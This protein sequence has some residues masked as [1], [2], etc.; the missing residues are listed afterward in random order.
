MTCC[1]SDQQQRGRIEAA[2]RHRV[3]ISDFPAFSGI[4]AGAPVPEMVAY[5]ATQEDIRQ[6]RLGY[7]IAAIICALLIA[8]ELALLAARPPHA[9]QVCPPGRAGSDAVCAVHHRHDSAAHAEAVR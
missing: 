3:S 2:A 4:C 6:F 5:L 8:L 9:R 7:T 1:S